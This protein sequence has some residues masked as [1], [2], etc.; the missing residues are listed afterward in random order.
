MMSGD[1][2][3]S[4]TT[5][6]LSGKQSIFHINSYWKKK[7]GAFICVIFKQPFVY[8]VIAASVLEQNTLNRIN[9]FLKTGLTVATISSLAV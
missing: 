1:P 8:S 4:N 5:F 9:F 2:K 3:F 6:K 7:R